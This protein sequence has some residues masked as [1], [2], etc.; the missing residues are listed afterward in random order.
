MDWFGFVEVGYDA[1]YH[2]LIWYYNSKFNAMLSENERTLET[3][4]Y[5][6]SP[7]IKP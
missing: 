3:S 1:A 5:K 2:I 7:T 6:I 4:Q